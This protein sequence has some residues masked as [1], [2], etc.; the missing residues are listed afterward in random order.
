MATANHLSITASPPSGATESHS[1]ERPHRSVILVEFTYSWTEFALKNL[2]R[3][4]L[5]S[6]ALGSS[7]VMCA[8]TRR[9][10][11]A[12]P[13]LHY[14]LCIII[15]VHPAMHAFDCHKQ[16][17]LIISTTDHAHMTCNLLTNILFSALCSESSPLRG[18]VRPSTLWQ[19]QAGRVCV[20]W[21]GQSQSGSDG[22]VQPSNSLPSGEGCTLVH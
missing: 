7:T 14:H 22:D 17:W 10:M 15:T 2:E 1:S 8:F 4:Q 6:L 19:E 9:V 11:R 12:Q 13:V 20:I 5:E 21:R 16:I 3:H 18:H